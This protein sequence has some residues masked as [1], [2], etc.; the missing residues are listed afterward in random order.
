MRRPES[1]RIAVLLTAV[2]AFGPISTD[3]YLP[4]LPGIARYFGTDAAAAQATLS[5]FLLGF[6]GGQIVYGPLS[7]RY[8]RRPVLLAGVAVYLA[9]TMACAIAETIEALIG[10]RFFQAL[11]AC[12]G[13]VLVRAIV[14]D[15]YAP[16]RA[17]SVLAYMGSAMAVAPM[18]GPVIGGQLEILFGWRANFVFLM[19]FAAL[20]LLSVVGIL[21][22]TNKRLDPS[23]LAPQRMLANFREM[24]ASPRYLGC[25]AG[26]TFCYSG[27]FAFISASS[28]V[29]IDVVGLTPDAFG[30]AFAIMVIGYMLGAVSAGRLIMRLGLDR[31]MLTGGILAAIGGPVMAAF[32]I[33]A[34]ED[35]AAIAI[36]IPMMFYAAGVGLVMPA[37][38]AAAIGPYPEK[39][40][41]ASSLL[42]FFQ[43]CFAAAT[44]ATVAHVLDGTARPMAVAIAVCGL[45]TLATILVLRRRV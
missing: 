24:L 7:D 6:A 29:L 39:A 23:A 30:I 41:A 3:L 27:L 28:F 44:G 32:A 18:I 25:L 9:A 15:I 37:T 45:A 14:R 2:V 10:A 34:A 13:V 11:G 33:L 22:E 5:V 40:G 19:V 1:L 8:G 26:A 4:S 21:D 20:I 43:M 36:V 38:T 42:G 16:E 12:S 35:V 31:T 17:G